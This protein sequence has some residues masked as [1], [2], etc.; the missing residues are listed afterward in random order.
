VLFR[1]V[2]DTN[3]RV[4]AGFYLFEADGKMS[5]FTGVYEVGGVKYFYTEGY[6]KTAGLVLFE[7]NYYYIS[8]NGR[9]MTG[10]VYVKDTNGLMNRGFYNFDAEGK[11]IVQ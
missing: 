3:G 4:T 11:M 2:K 9:V 6:R 5:S 8:T 1:S 10:W 7:E